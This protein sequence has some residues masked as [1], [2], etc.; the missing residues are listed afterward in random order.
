[1]MNNI[2]ENMFWISCWS[3]R[4]LLLYMS[5]MY[6]GMAD[7]GT[8]GTAYLWGSI[9]IHLQHPPT[10]SSIAVLV[11]P[12]NFTPFGLSCHTPR[13]KHSSPRS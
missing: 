6:G 2:V 11:M 10:T 13:A 3:L 4:V 5:W 9:Y 12:L 7:V 1:M 8:A